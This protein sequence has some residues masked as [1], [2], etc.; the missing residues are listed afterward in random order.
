[1][2]LRL[3]RLAT[4]IRDMWVLV[5]TAAVLGALLGGAV[6]FFRPAQ[7]TA[8]TT[9]FVVTQNGDSA[10]SAYQGGLLSQQ[11]V[12][13]Y[14]E[15]V[16]S[17]RVLRGVIAQTGLDV[18]PDR[19]AAKVEATNPPDSVVIMIEASDPDPGLAA[20]IAN[21]TG[22]QLVDLVRT[23]EI[24]SR[25]GDAP[26]ISVRTVQAAAAPLMPSSPP[27]ILYPVLGLLAGLMIGVVA[28][29][30][31]GRIDTRIRSVGDLN[32]ASGSPNLGVV[33]A[34]PDLA[35]GPIPGDAMTR[36]AEEFRRLR[37]SFVFLGVDSPSRVMLVSS[38]V[39]GEGKSTVAGNLAVVLAAAG[40]R[41]LVIDGDMRRPRLSE[42]FEAEQAVGLSS[43]LSNK[44]EMGSA[45]QR[46]SGGVDLMTSGPIPPNPSELLA[47]QRLVDVLQRLRRRYSSIIIDSPPLLP[48]TDAAAAAPSVDGVILVCKAGNTSRSKLRTAIGSLT[49]VGAPVVGTV[50]TMAPPRRFQAYGDYSGYEAVQEIPTAGRP[51]RATQDPDETDILEG[52]SIAESSP[53]P[54]PRRRQ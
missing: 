54:S 45:I 5:L 21:A 51:K 25:P 24:P 31:Y 17:T 34:S 29:L 35:S 28:V 43:V 52:V 33:T 12:K 37:T 48:V 27:P 7:Y 22:Q 40:E 14:T 19:L 30:L 4:R 53:S 47:S 15:L 20:R 44:V 1:M 2:I 3:R 23:L 26:A 10:Q 46:T 11:R 16:T 49:K 6:I 18:N 32:E 50:L 8:S 39:A 38:S 42:M 41:V 13:S 36:S 9:L